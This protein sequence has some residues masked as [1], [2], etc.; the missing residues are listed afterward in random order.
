L[1]CPSWQF[2]LYCY[3]GHSN[4]V[5]EFGREFTRREI[6]P[7]QNTGTMRFDFANIAAV[8]L[9]HILKDGLTTLQTAIQVLQ[10]MLHLGS[11]R[12][13]DGLIIR[14]LS[15]IHC[16]SKSA[17]LLLLNCAHSRMSTEVV[18]NWTAGSLIFRMAVT[19]F[20]LNTTSRYYKIPSR[21]P[22]PN[23]LDISCRAC[24]LSIHN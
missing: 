3:T 15:F 14:V 17:N 22:K 7:L 18:S 6:I 2:L 11:I 9:L 13:P 19:S 4:R 1:I 5:N 12:L 23:D 20:E 21:F 16:R 10:F 8:C 24:L